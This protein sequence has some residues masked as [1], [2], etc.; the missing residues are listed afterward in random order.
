[1]KQSKTPVVIVKQKAAFQTV[2]CNCPGIHAGDP[3]ANYCIGFSRMCF[4][5]RGWS[6]AQGILFI[7]FPRHECQGNTKTVAT[8]ENVPKQN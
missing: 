2:A 5:K 1:M 6:K 7:K 4:I 3:F 8:I